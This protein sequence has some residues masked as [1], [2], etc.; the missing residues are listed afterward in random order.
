MEDSRALHQTLVPAI[1]SMRD[2]SAPFS[3]HDMREREKER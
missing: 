2:M 1:G 3:V